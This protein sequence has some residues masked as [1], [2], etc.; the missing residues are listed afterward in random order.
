LG[1][2][3]IEVLVEAFFGRLSCVDLGGRRI[4]KKQP[5]SLTPKKRGPDQCAP[6]MARATADSDR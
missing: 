2:E 1:I 3:G 5:Y 6:V 4:I